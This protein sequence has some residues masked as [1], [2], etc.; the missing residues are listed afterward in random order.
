VQVGEGEAP[1]E[2][3]EGQFSPGIIAGFVEEDPPELPVVRVD[4]GKLWSLENKVIVF[5]RLVVRRGQKEAP[6]HAEMQLEVATALPGRSPGLRRR[7]EAEEQ[8]FPMG[9]AASKGPAGEGLFDVPGGS[10]P[11]DACARM[12]VHREYTLAVARFP[13]ASGEFDFSE[14][15][16]GG[17]AGWIARQSSLSQRFRLWLL[18]ASSPFCSFR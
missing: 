3:F 8:A 12:A 1:I 17:Q 6:C 10:V 9:P 13:D 16:H 5:D 14:F 2:D 4:Q 18:A 7:R 11:I 15:R